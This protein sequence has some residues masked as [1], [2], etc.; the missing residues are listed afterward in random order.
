MSLTAVLMTGD[1]RRHRWV[2]RQLGNVLDLRCVVVEA[3]RNPVGPNAEPAFDDVVMRHFAR[4]ESVESAMLGSPAPL[5]VEMIRVPTG[6]INRIDLYERVAE[7]KPDVVI[8]YGTG[9]IRAPLLNSFE[10]RLVN[11]HL[12]LSPYYRGAGTNFWPLVDGKPECVGATIHLVRAAVD[13]GPVLHQVRPSAKASDDAHELGT[14]ALM[15]AVDVLPDAVSNFLRGSIRARPQDLSIG[16]V[17]KRSDFDSSAV[18]RLSR[19]LEDGMMDDYVRDLAVRQEAFPIVSFG[20][21]DAI[22]SDT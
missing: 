18:L 11:L 20:E 9:I 12:G 10:D 7:M 22:P 14:R 16:K 6:E 21:L 13:A 17:F 1:K 3:K 8:V 2:A 19:N 4:R 15:A 5:D